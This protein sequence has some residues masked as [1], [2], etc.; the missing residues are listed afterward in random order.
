MRLALYPGTF[1]PVTHGH[2]DI[3]ERA[4]SLFD[5]VIVTVGRN[6]T[7][8]PLF[9][10]EERVSLI[11]QSAPDERIEVAAFD[12]L[13]VN[14]A[15]EQGAAAIVRGLRQVADFEYEFQMALMNRTL[16]PSLTTLFLMPH[17]RYT[18][19]NSSM[20]REVARLGGDVSPFVPPVV[21]DALNR[22]FGRG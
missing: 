6:S 10:A 15:Q 20:V 21:L 14:F 2:L 8:T 12:G 9:S 18:F 13:L 4:L 7:K 19:L 11:R 3:L 22:K 1:D 17:E 16:A 5:R